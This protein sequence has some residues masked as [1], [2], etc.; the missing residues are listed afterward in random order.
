VI[1]EAVIAH[2]RPEPA[3]LRVDVLPSRIS[4][5]QASALA[6]WEAARGP[7]QPMVAVGGDELSWLGIDL[8]RFPGF[9]IAGPPLSGRST[10]LLV[11]A[12][13]LLAGGAAVV[14]FAPRDS[15]LRKLEGRAG[16]TE[17]FTAASPDQVALARL[18]EAAAGPLAIL[19]DDAEA[20]H[21]AP[22]ADLIAQIPVE[23]RGRGQALVVAG[24]SGE[25]LRSQRSFTAA[26]RQFRCGLLLTPE[27]PQLGQELFGARL[28]RSAAFDHPPGRGYLIRA[29]QATLAQ[30]PKP[31]AG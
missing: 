27:A 10:A 5:V 30:V 21:H 16:V 3:P 26:A 4:H 25:L 18:L 1:R 28:P 22:V 7:L 8:A 24:T 17:M 6:G 14:G 23:G 11:I 29:G 12:E 15:P 19:V 20:L 13:S 31:A 2:G 9:A